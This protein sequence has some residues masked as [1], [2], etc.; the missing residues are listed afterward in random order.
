MNKLNEFDEDKWR[1]RYEREV[2]LMTQ[3]CETLNK[4]SPVNIYKA[5]TEEEFE[6]T[7]YEGL[8]DTWIKI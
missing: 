1:K 4:D 7:K 5:Y 8:D 2:K 6:K 3:R